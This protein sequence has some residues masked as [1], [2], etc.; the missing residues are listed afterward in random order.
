MRIDRM[1]SIIVMLLN[2]DKV[3][4]RELADKF[5]VS[6]RTIYRDIDAINLAGIPIVSYSGNNGGFGILKNYMIDRQLLSL[7]DMASI[8]SVLKGFNSTL[9]NK[10]MDTAI[11]KI[12]SLVPR[13]RTDDLSLY[14]EQVVLDI[15]PWG[16]SEKHRMNLKIIHEAILKNILLEIEYRNSK[17]E[18]NFRSIEPMTL[19]FKGSAWYL[20]AY[21]LLKNDYRLFRLSRIK[22]INVLDKIFIRRNKSYHYLAE[23]NSYPEIVNLVLKFKK[24]IAQRVEEFFDEESITVLENG[25]LI[26]KI[27]FPL[28][29]W[30]YSIIL[31]Y[32]EYV[33][34]LE[35]LFVREIIINRVKNVL[36]VYKN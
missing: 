36:D 30:V 4:A 9:Q 16:F 34:V 14:M 5:E 18:N 12:K 25:D 8:I 17:G 33:E 19:L 24:D 32:G 23:Q 15:L 28:D 10:D 20:F 3:K 2:K 1:L 22:N 29:E 21:C 13:D 31:S 35:P 6:I 7:K 11:E 26:V 27:G